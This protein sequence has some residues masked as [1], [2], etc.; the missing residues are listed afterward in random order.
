MQCSYTVTF[1]FS[2]NNSDCETATRCNRHVC[3]GQVYCSSLV[4]AWRL[5]S[6]SELCCCSVCS[7]ASVGTYGS[8][9][10][11]NRLRVYTLHYH[12]VE[13]VV[14]NQWLKWPGQAGDGGVGIWH[15]FEHKRTLFN[16]N[17][18][19]FSLASG[20]LCY[21]RE[22][23]QTRGPLT[24]IFTTRA[25]TLISSLLLQT[26]SACHVAARLNHLTSLSSRR[27]IF[28]YASVIL[29]VSLSPR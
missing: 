28:T 2:D 20:S 6:R 26:S 24:L 27:F 11:T 15:T 23:A 12:V 5:E 21:R 16:V 29:S 18:T 17:N 10:R 8:E 22:G 14:S 9:R 4:S 25:S 7:I 19:I 13:R 3:Y 1:G